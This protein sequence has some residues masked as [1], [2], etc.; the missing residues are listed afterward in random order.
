MILNVSI[1]V[2]GGI[3]VNGGIVSGT[4]TQLVGGVIATYTIIRIVISMI[5][6]DRIH[7]AYQY[8]S[9]EI[10]TNDTSN[11]V[12]EILINLHRGV[13]ILNV[14]GAFSHNPKSMIICVIATYELPTLQEIVR[15]S[16][17][18]AFVVVK[19]VKTV[20]GNFKRKTIA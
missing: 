5:L 4:D 8:L 12:E 19:P 20:M 3:V 17:D 13:T 1:A 2:L 18:K 15:R 6:T 16:D 9:V 14:F 7:T 11:L 10:I